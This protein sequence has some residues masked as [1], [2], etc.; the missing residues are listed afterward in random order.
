MP[1]RLKECFLNFLLHLWQMI[2]WSWIFLKAHSIYNRVFFSHS[3]RWDIHKVWV[4]N[5]SE[6]L[7]SPITPIERLLRWDHAVL[8]FKFR[9][10]S[11]F[12]SSLRNCL[13]AI[14]S[15]G[16]SQIKKNDLLR[17][18]TIKKSMRS[19]FRRGLYWRYL[20]TVDLWLEG[21]GKY[22]NVP[23]LEF[24]QY[25]ACTLGRKWLEKCQKQQSTLMKRE[26]LWC[27]RGMVLHRWSRV[28]ISKI[29]SW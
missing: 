15:L 4:D 13:D 8:C 2:F 12:Q 28:I 1:F 14:G 9:E 17:N 24:R 18:R 21:S 26:N 29:W 19:F 3:D 27:S 6:H 7:I 22:Q 5:G 20:A 10:L 25:I 16:A 23:K 11:S